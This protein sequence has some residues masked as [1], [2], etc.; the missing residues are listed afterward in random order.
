MMSSTT[1]APIR[2]GLYAS[3][4]ALTGLGMMLMPHRP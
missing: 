3:T 1:A 2:I 4:N